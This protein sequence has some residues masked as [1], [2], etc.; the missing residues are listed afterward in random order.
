MD[1]EIKFLKKSLMYQMSLGSRELFHSNV[2]AW[3]ME[4]DNNFITVFFNDF[5]VAQYKSIKVCRE[6]YNR[7]ITIWLER[8]N[9]N[10]DRF[11][12]LVIENKIK[13]LPNIEQLEKYSEDLNG[14]R[15]SKAVFTGLINPYLEGQTKTAIKG[16]KEEI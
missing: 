11:V 2:W 3:L 6:K 13:T 7:D 1:K 10:I 8:K 15:I 5:D 4:M 16:R 9:V 14:Y 12:Y